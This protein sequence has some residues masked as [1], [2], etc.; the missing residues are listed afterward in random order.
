M[1]LAQ[2]VAVLKP[3]ILTTATVERAPDRRGSACLVEGASRC[4]GLIALSPRLEGQRTG[5]GKGL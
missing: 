1:L 4:P 3:R 2:G 5:A